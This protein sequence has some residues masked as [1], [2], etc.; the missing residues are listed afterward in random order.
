MIEQL[1]RALE[2]VNDLYPQGSFSF[3]RTKGSGRWGCY[4][5]RG[6]GCVHG[7]GSTPTHAFQDALA[8]MAEEYPDDETVRRKRATELRAELARLEAEQQ[9]AV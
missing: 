3:H 8:K 7:T 9:E 2:A 4:L 5:H 6:T 1:D